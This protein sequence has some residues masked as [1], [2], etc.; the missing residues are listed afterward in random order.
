VGQISKKK[1][2]RKQESGHAMT[3]EERLI[4]EEK[5]NNKIFASFV[6]V[7]FIAVAAFYPIF[8]RLDEASRYV[9][10]TQDKTYFY[11]L[12]TAASALAFLVILFAV[13][14]KPNFEN[15]YTDDEPARRFS[16]AEWALFAFIA[17]AFISAVI[18]WTQNWFGGIVWWG[19]EK[20]YEGFISYLCYAAAFMLVA[21]FYKPKRLHLLIIAGSAVF[22]SLYGVLQFLGVDILKLFPY[23]RQDLLSIGHLTAFFRTTLGNVNIVSAYCS[24]AILLFTGLY[25]GARSK[26]QYLYLGAGLASF[27]LSLTTGNSGDAHAVAVLGAMVLLIPYWIASR[28]RLSRIFIMLSGWCVIY[29]GQSAYLSVMKRRLENGEDFR[30]SDANF[31]QAYEHKNIALFLI[32]AAGLLA[33]G[34]CMLYLLRTWPVRAFKMVGVGILPVIILCAVIGLE[35]LGT[36]FADNPDNI[37]W[38]AREMMHGRLE[39]DFGS[40]RGW[41]WKRAVSVIPDNPVFG[42]GPDTF[43]YALGEELQMEAGERYNIKFD[44]AHNIFLQIA[45][46]MGIPALLAYLAFLGGVFVPAVKAAFDRPVLLAFGAASLSYVIQSFFCVEVPITTP[47]V[48]ISLGVMACEVWR[49]KIGCENVE[50]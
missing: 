49:S 27:A 9:Y 42:T 20:R 22:I 39:D 33:A 26:W 34:L 8:I 29:A 48:W 46:C 11:W 4:L 37:I 5:E 40:S 13:K 18:S 15:Y 32:L 10:M 24:F 45:V 16:I 38:Q 36:R 14:F 6:S 23:E 19:A 21:R 7:F 50:L 30:W 41:V 44:K 25:A 28:E 31:L 35:M 43:E 3:K 2:L 17:W 1:R 47:L 12:L